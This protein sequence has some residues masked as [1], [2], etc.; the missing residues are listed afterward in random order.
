M[1]IPFF[2]NQEL[3]PMLIAMTPVLIL[4]IY[5]VLSFYSVKYISFYSSFILN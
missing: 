1:V 3:T 5:C 4:Y 2:D